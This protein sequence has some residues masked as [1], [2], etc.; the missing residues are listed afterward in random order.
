[1]CM[2]SRQKSVAEWRA[3]RGYKERCP[4]RNKKKERGR[5]MKAAD[6]FTCSRGQLL[7]GERD[8]RNGNGKPLCKKER[9]ITSLPIKSSMVS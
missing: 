5:D 4:K 1:M 3:K 8:A 6:R 7:V 2:R 9:A